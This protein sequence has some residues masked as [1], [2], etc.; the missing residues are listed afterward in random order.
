MRRLVGDEYQSVSQPELQPLPSHALLFPYS[1]AGAYTDC[2]SIDVAGAVSIEQFVA[3]FYTSSLFKMERWVLKWAVA[4]PSTDDEARQFSSGTLDRFAAWTVEG[5]TDT[6]F[7]ACDYQGRTRSWLMVT[8]KVGATTLSFGSA[9]VAAPKAG[10]RAGKAPLIFR[11]LTGPHR[12]YA[13]ALLRS[14]VHR[15]GQ[16]KP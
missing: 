12:L 10:S 4:K 2:Y 16:F 6:Q 9:V 7:L 3:A 13:K 14:A 1:A 11:L 8:P 5:R 15:L